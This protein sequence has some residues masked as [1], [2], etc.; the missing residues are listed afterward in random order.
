MGAL[1]EG[2]LSLISQAKKES[3]VVV[4]SIFINPRQFN[5]EEDFRQYPKS[6]SQDAEMLSSVGCNV[7]FLPP[8][9]EMYPTRAKLTI[10]MGRID[11]VLEG[12]H[13]P[14]HFSGVALIV[15]KLLNMVQPDL[16]WL[17]QKDLQQVAVIRQLIN[18]LSFQVALKIGETIREQDGLAM[19]SR[20]RRLGQADRDMAPALYATLLKIRNSIF[21]SNQSVSD[22][23]NHEIAQLALRGI[24]I[25]YLTIVDRDTFEATEDLNLI[26]GSHGQFH[27]C[28]AAD[29][30]GVRLIDNISLIP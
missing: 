4:S 29:I 11:E 19:S 1:H 15:S 22:L 28:I 12:S 3:D 18:E 13:R 24:K 17:G 6:E 20:N 10:N 8:V 30:N 26:K 27:V 21:N 14:G 25:E 16:L 2:H 7:L 9:H 23:I 5:S